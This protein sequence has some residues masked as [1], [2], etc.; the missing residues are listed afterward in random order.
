MCSGN[1]F[2]FYKGLTQQVILCRP[3]L[4]EPDEPPFWSCSPLKLVCHF[5]WRVTFDFFFFF[6]GG[7]RR[8]NKGEAS[9]PAQ[10]AGCHSG[11][12]HSAELA[13]ACAHSLPPVRVEEFRGKRPLSDTIVSLFVSR[14]VTVACSSSSLP[15]FGTKIFELISWLKELQDGKCVQT[16]SPDK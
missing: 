15:S 3:V 6:L 7:K 13:G 9:E 10:A 11:S 8:K 1:S 16:L 4:T 2:L 12:G 5:T 14:T